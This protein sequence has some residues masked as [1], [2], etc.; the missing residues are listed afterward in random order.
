MVSC[1]FSNANLLIPNTTSMQ[2]YFKWRQ[3]ISVPLLVNV[4]NGQIDSYKTNSRLIPN[5]NNYYLDYLINQ[6]PKD[7]EYSV[8]NVDGSWV[9]T[10]NLVPSK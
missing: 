9:V 8:L 7:H 2:S 5:N 6:N 1:T 3:L 10:T 4:N